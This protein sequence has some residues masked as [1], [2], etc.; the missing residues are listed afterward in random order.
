[1][2]FFSAARRKI[3]VFISP[4][5]GDTLRP[6]NTPPTAT[7]RPL[8]SRLG[9]F[10]L[11]A[12]VLHL[13]GT[14]LVPLADRDEPWY[15][16]VSR[17]MNERGD[18]TV[19]YFNNQF[20]LEKP[21]L[22]YWG[23]SAAYKVFGDNEFGARFPVSLAAALTALV[24]FGF[25]ARLY[26]RATA[27]RAAIAFTLCLWMIYFGKWGGTDTP[28]MLFLTL[29][30]WAGW[31]LLGATTPSP[32]SKTGWWWIFYVSLAVAF[33]AKGPVIVLPLGGLAIFW[34]WTRVPKFFTT[35]KFVRGLAVTG[36]LAALWFVPAVIG[37][38]GEYLKV[39]IGQQVMQRSV[40]A[41]DGHGAS[42]AIMYL[43]W[44]PY[45]FLLLIPQFLPWTFYF[46]Q[47]WKRWKTE[48]SPADIYLVSCIAITLV[49]FSLVRTKLPS[50]SL[51]VFPLV[52]C[53]VAPVLAGVK[54]FTRLAAVM[55][56]LNLFVAFAFFPFAAR[57]SAV[58]ELANNPA[59]QTNMAFASADYHE[60]SIVWIFRKHLKAWHEPLQVNAVTDY[61]NRP[62]AR[63]CVLPTKDLPQVKLD[64]SWKVITARGFNITRGRMIELAMLV[65]SS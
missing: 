3:I 51:P 1:M 9:I 29:S 8:L 18:Y 6:L 63:L 7:E 15:A 24:V 33:L 65:K 36:I 28:A 5:S 14:W 59:V 12:L 61:M 35:M 42:N 19:S 37:T 34:W 64:P 55:V 39:F 38:H 58:T 43:V 45:Y 21:P 46:P 57:Y 40:T 47:T 41:M 22:L 16:E 62:G 13:A 50:Y 31:E 30:V 54:H 27:W 48:R 10:F 2:F 17:E 49:L 11:L 44:L 25:C 4:I 32:V 20:W 60:P 53:L 23:Q 52:A 26:N 56:G